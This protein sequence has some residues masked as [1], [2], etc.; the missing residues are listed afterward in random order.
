MERHFDR[1]TAVCTCSSGGVAGAEVAAPQLAPHLCVQLPHRRASSLEPPFTF[2]L[3][4][5]GK[6][7]TIP[8]AIIRNTFRPPCADC[9]AT[10]AGPS[11]SSNSPSLRRA[12]EYENVSR[13]ALLWMASLTDASARLQRAVD[14][15]LV[16]PSTENAL[17]SLAVV[18]NFHRHSS[19]NIEQ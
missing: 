12:S 11:M 14:R 19:F 7:C 13:V 8:I 2:L 5:P 9:H 18:A 1:S 3:Y 15:R 16:V 4:T 10:V 17:L 6:Q